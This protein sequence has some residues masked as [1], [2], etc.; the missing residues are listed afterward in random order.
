MIIHTFWN[1]GEDDLP[2]FEK[3]CIASWRHHLTD[4]DIRICD[5]HALFELIKD[6]Q[7]REVLEVSS[8]QMQ[9]DIA[10]LILLEMYGGLWM[11]AAILV[12]NPFSI[13]DAL[14]RSA[15]ADIVGYEFTFGAPG[16]KDKILTSWFIAVRRAKHPFIVAWRVALETM[17]V[18]AF[19][20]STVTAFKQIGT[21]WKSKS[22]T[23]MKSGLW[24]TYQHHVIGAAYLV[25]HVAYVAATR[26]FGQPAVKM[27][28]SDGVLY[29]H[30]HR[31]DNNK[32]NEPFPIVKFTSEGRHNITRY[33]RPRDVI[34]ELESYAPHA[35]KPPGGPLLDWEIWAIACAAILI[36]VVITITVVCCMNARRGDKASIELRK[37]N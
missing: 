17:I 10:R 25:I 7:V 36:A 21:V 20:S 13:D 35:L 18:E 34:V 1:N 15:G 6:P 8:P 26:R 28:S 31:H 23:I 4:A 37:S 33:R 3:A 12:R 30:G 11:D 32:I 2:P 9:S 14:F 22:I 27:Y 19:A 29:I 5:L 16:H 24:R